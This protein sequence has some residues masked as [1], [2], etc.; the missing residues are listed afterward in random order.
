MEAG[1]RGR[2]PGIY[3]LYVLVNT[4]PFVGRQFMENP[5]DADGIVWRV[6]GP[7]IPMM[8]SVV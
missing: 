5:E 7:E 4:M 3:E 1:L 2:G 6:V 8:H